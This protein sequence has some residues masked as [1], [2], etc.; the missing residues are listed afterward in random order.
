MEKIARSTT[1][2]PLVGHLY[3]NPPHSAAVWMFFFTPLFFGGG[4]GRFSAQVSNL[5]A[6]VI[7]LTAT[8]LGRLHTPG[9]PGVAF[10][11][12]GKE[13]KR[14]RGV[15]FF[16][17]IEPRSNRGTKGYKTKADWRHGRR[18]G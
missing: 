4:V 9:R 8:M 15:L 2:R 3:S 10:Q 14:G 11:A 12:L 17:F 16:L 18:N 5:R 6:V 1:C 13:Q 7:M